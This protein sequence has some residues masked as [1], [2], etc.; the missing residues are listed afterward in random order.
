MIDN[1]GGSMPMT[2][3]TTA[4]PA[5]PTGPSEPAEGVAALADRRMLDLLRRTIARGTTDDEFQLFLARCRQ[6]RL[7][8]FARQIYAIKRWDRREQREVMTIQIS[9]DGARLQAERT[10]KY[11]GQLGPFWCGPDGEW[12]DVWL[13]DTPPAAAK[14]GILRSDFREPLWAVARF[15]S[16]CQRTADGRPQGLWRT[17]GDLMIAKCAEMLGLRRAFPAELAGLYTAEE[18]QQAANDIVADEESPR[19]RA[20]TPAHVETDAAPADATETV[21]AT[22]D[23]DPSS[24]AALRA[25]AQRTGTDVTKLCAFFHV[26]C[27]EDL[28]PRD[29]RQAL[30]MLSKKESRQKREAAAQADEAEA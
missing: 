5:P 24:P 15:E 3:P 9:I 19:H 20:A 16:Y 21:A 2:T 30:M 26:E 27:L 8:P 23:D 14:V 18:M 17:M 7:D 6:T 25:L 13:E 22:A 10:G 28:P 12:R 4:P 29:R 1:G 11:A